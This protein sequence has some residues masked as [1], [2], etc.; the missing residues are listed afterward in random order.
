[1]RAK[2]ISMYIYLIIP[3]LIFIG[4]TEARFDPEIIVGIWSLD[5]GNGNEAGD[6]SE[7]GRN[8][9]IQGASWVDGKIGDALDFK[10]G[11][12]VVVT[13]G[14]GIV[15]DKVSIVLWLQFTDL[16]GQQNYYPEYIPVG[17][18]ILPATW[19]RYREALDELVS[20]HPIIFGNI[21][22]YTWSSCLAEGGPEIYWRTP[23]WLSQG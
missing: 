9:I 2:L 10:K 14:D 11:D 7:N 6:S 18:G 12:T 1:M 3:A 17:V 16:S 8:G 13:L 15:T 21:I 20:W 23:L 22:K 19:I 5:E 4:H